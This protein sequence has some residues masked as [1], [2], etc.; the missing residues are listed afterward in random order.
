[1]AIM[2][3]MVA[4]LAVEISGAKRKP[5][6]R[7]LRVQFVE[8]DPRL[9]ARPAFLRI[10]FEQAVEIFRRVDHDAFADRLPGLRSSSAAHR[11][12][13]A[14]AAAD[15]DHANHI[16]AMPGN[17]DARGLDLIHARVG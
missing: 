5:K 17:H 1:M 13:A 7:K 16:L 11:D 8:H 15:L 12:G 4:R 14:Q 2:P 6:R 9:D 10:H 3:P